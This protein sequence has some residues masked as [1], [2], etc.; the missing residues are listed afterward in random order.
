MSLKATARS[1]FPPGHPEAR[2]VLV[3]PVGNVLLSYYQCP[4]TCCQTHQFIEVQEPSLRPGPGVHHG[5]LAA[6]WEHRRPQLVRRKIIC[7]EMLTMSSSLSSPSSPS[8]SSSLS[9]SSSSSPSAREKRRLIHMARPSLAN[10]TAAKRTFSS[11]RATGQPP[12]LNTY[13]VTPQQANYSYTCCGMK[14]PILT[15]EFKDKIPAAMRQ[16]YLGLFIEVCLK[17]SS[18]RL[19][20]IEKAQSEEKVIYDQSPSKN[21]YLNVALHTLKKL[22]GLVPSA[23]PSLSK[24]TLY[25]RLRDYLLTEEQRKVH[26]FPFVHPAKQGSAILFKQKQPLSSS[27]RACCRCGTK[28]PVSPSGGCLC[29]EPCVYHWGRALSI[30]VQGGWQVRYSCCNATVEAAG[31]SVAKQHVQDR[32]KDNLSGFAKTFRKKDWEAH[33]GIYALDCEMSYTTHGLELTRV[34]VVDTNLHVIYDTFV[35]PDNEIVDYNTRFSGVTEADLV[36]T[37]VRLCDVQATLLN[38][39]STETI[40][41]GHSLECDLL[42]LKF[43]HGTVVDTSVLF[44]HYRGL[45]YKRSLRGLVSQYLNRKIQGHSSGHCSIEDASACM[46]LVIWKIQEDIKTSS[47]PQQ[48]AAFQKSDSRPKLRVCTSR[49]TQTPKMLEMPEMPDM[50]LEESDSHQ[51]PQLEI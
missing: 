7:P 51:S 6:P 21:K 11:N 38:L 41:I 13:R 26:G 23:I 45:P 14:K 28:F 42:A 4:P 25:S 46:Q 48:Q 19:E 22:R 40:L 44:P 16:H 30:R 32:R 17:F 34:S 37:N 33:A 15:K 3:H 24:A 47:P 31:C 39:F 9:S 36:N 20:A 8:S 49:Y 35:K 43:I 29:S 12:H 2:R 18:S 1:W 5:W 27:H 50:Y 10:T